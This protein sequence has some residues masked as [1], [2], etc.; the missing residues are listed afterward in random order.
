MCNI[1]DYV[2]TYGKDSMKERHFCSADALVLAQLSYINW[3]S[4]IPEL[5]DNKPFISLRETLYAGNVEQMVRGSVFKESNRDLFY[6]TANSP[7]FGGIKMNFYVEMW[8]IERNMQVS[9]LTCI[10]PCGMACVI[11][12]GTD[13][14]LNGWQENFSM[15]YRFPVPAQE[16]ACIYLRQVAKQISE[17]LILCGHSKGGNLAAYAAAMCGAEIQNRIRRIYNFDGPGFWTNF[18]ES[19][20]YASIRPRIRK[21][22]APESLIGLLLTDDART[23]IVECNAHG[24]LQH[25]PYQ[26]ELFNGRLRKARKFNAEKRKAAEQLN[27]KILT[28]SKDKAE[29][30]IES[31]FE[32][33]NDCGLSKLSEV[34]SDYAL[35]VLKK[36]H[37]H[38]I[39]DR[40]CIYVLARILIYLIPGRKI[41]R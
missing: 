36:F 13:E 27:K 9:A 23:F 31:F 14:S 6:L 7:R 18:L 11:Y 34:N 39:Y 8:N 12:M 19:K 10:L 41:L 3:S 40:D 26:W 24:M 1:L 2:R 28:I 29:T 32:A 20:E 21:Y 15:V 38:G 4:A 22:L 30:V 37:S 17:P 5:K 33:L 35:A 25:D 16:Y